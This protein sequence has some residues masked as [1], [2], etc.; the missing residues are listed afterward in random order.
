MIE[1]VK[2]L[3]NVWQPFCQFPLLE[4]FLNEHLIRPFFIFCERVCHLNGSRCD[5][6][7]GIQ[8]WHTLV[9]SG[10]SWQMLR[11]L[12]F[13]IEFIACFALQCYRLIDHELKLLQRGDNFL[14]RLLF[15]LHLYYLLGQS[16]VHGHQ[17][18]LYILLLVQLFP[19][20]FRRTSWLWTFGLNHIHKVLLE[21]LLRG[22]TLSH[23]FKLVIQLLA[24]FIPL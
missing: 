22:E 4:T 19:V 15:G 16:L 1:V 14:K 6:L 11:V 20:F 13:R 12:I 9:F 18:L 23:S 7:L 17:L 8:S 3:F 2:E 10:A 24:F 21:L 5:I